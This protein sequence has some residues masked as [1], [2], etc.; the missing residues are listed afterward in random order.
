[1]AWCSKIF[2]IWKRS[3]TFFSSSLNNQRY[4]LHFNSVTECHFLLW[5]TKIDWELNALE[6]GIAPLFF[7]FVFFSCSDWFTGAT[8]TK[9]WCPIHSDK[10]VNSL[11]LVSSS[12][13]LLQW[14]LSLKCH[15]SNTLCHL[16]QWQ[17]WMFCPILLCMF[18]QLFFFFTKCVPS[19]YLCPLKKREIISI[20][21]TYSS[22]LSSHVICVCHVNACIWQQFLVHRR[23]MSN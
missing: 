21:V 14:A 19:G 23:K 22:W 12:T 15:Q 10:K 5:Q 20:H 16:Y 6:S 17:T 4:Y 8:V 2:W 7:F 13:G 11:T 3:S 9:S 18:L 1:M